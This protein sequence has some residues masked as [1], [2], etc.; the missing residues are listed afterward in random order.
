M[1][2]PEN[3][4]QIMCTLAQNFEVYYCDIASHCEPGFKG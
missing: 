3:E 2:V 1:N 4:K